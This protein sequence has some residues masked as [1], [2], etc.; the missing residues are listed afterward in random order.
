MSN[1]DEKF[2]AIELGNCTG[3]VLRFAAA[4]I[5]MDDV[6]SWTTCHHGERRGEQADGAGLFEQ[7]FGVGD[8]LPKVMAMVGEHAHAVGE[9]G[10]GLGAGD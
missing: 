8:H 2:Y 4:G 7:V 9:V 3:V 1:E 5:T 6:S 10:G